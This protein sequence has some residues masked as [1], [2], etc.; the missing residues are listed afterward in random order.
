MLGDLYCP[1][2]F[3]TCQHLWAVC[4]RNDWQSWSSSFIA[5]FMLYK[6]NK[7]SFFNFKK[8][9]L[10]V[11]QFYLPPFFNLR[12]YFS[13]TFYSWKTFAAICAIQINYKCLNKFSLSFC[14]VVHMLYFLMFSLMVGFRLVL[15]NQSYFFFFSSFRHQTESF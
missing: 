15:F 13:L 14:P 7:T 3:Y 5:Y 11:A 10:L 2:S 4:R 8:S 6:K 9:F 1:F 12:I